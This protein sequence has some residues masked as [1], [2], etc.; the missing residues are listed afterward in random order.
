[1]EQSGELLVVI[2]TYNEVDNIGRML[3]TLLSGSTGCHV[4][5]VDDNSP[6]GTRGV[7][8]QLQPLYAGRLHLLN[9][10]GKEGLGKAYLAGFRW[11]LEHPQYLFILEMDADFSHSPQD[12]PRL[13][14]CCRD[15]GADLAVGSRYRGGFRVKNWPLSRILIS[16][17]ASLYV[18]LITGMSIRD[19]TAG[20]VCYRAEALRRILQAPIRMRGYGFQIEMKYVAH[21]L[22]CRIREVDI[23]FTDRELGVSKMSGGIFSEAL[24]GVVRMRLRVPGEVRRLRRGG[25]FR[26]KGEGA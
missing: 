9:R 24:L 19:T 5:V 3:E 11:A 23:V 14:A 13:Y 6:D 18:R 21:C 16:Y 2:P 12:V 15:R 7:V 20:F 26:E 10:A 8:E 22:G 25:A 4:L 1:M 17:S